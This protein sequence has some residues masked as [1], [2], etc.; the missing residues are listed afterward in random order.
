MLKK[1]IKFY[2]N[3]STCLIV[4]WPVF[5]F[6]LIILIAKVSL[7]WIL[8]EIN[9]R[10]DYYEELEK[11][12]L[13]AG[14][15]FDAFLTVIFFVCLGTVLILI[16]QRDYQQSKSDL[17]EEEIINLM[18][19]PQRL[20]TKFIICSFLFL[21]IS[22][23]MIMQRFANITLLFIEIFNSQNEFKGKFIFQLSM[24]V[25]RYFF[26]FLFCLTILIFHFN[27]ADLKT[28]E[29][30]GNNAEE[31]DNLMGGYDDIQGE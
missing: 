19:M 18:N 2:Q 29:D 12:I 27:K 7:L 8:S 16:W 24:C 30:H 10:K 3:S 13:L 6:I 28:I 15:S 5:I 22:L 9:S 23:F 17:T 11:Y 4:Y 26:D 25:S 21:I 14:Y 1:R 20:P 31:N